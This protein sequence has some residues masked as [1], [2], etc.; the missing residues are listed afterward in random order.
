MLPF[1]R[2]IWS[3]R[4][5]TIVITVGRA[6]IGTASLDGITR[7]IRPSYPVGVAGFGMCVKL[8]APVI[9]SIQASGRAQTNFSGAEL[10]QW[11]GC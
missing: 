2:G 3:E 4:D 5:R 6:A 7:L 10:G 11:H 1:L 8:T 9:N